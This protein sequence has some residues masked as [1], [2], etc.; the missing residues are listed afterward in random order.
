M[1]TSTFLKALT[2][3]FLFTSLISCNNDTNPGTVFGI[4]EVIDEQTIEMNGEIG[5]AA[6]DDFNELVDAY[7]DIRLINIAEVPGSFDDEVNLEVSA[8][9]NRRNIATHLLEGGLIAS[10]GVDFFL[11]GTT[12]TRGENTMIGVHAWSDGTNEASDYPRGNPNHQPY[13]DYY[14]SIGFTRAEAEAFYYFTINAAPSSSIHY[15][16]EQEIEQYG[17]LRP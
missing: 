8:A 4:F 14:Q 15:M 1:K 17:I 16:T 11:A 9:V 5:S 3:A 7:P 13:I 10:G 6:L 2:V 12:R